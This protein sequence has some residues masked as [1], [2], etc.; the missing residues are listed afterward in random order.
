MGRRH[1]SQGHLTLLP[2]KTHVVC[3]VARVEYQ[4]AGPV[5]LF[6]FKTAIPSLGLP[7]SQAV[8]SGCCL[9]VDA[10]GDGAA[11][12]ELPDLRQGVHALEPRPLRDLM[13]IAFQCSMMNPCPSPR[14]AFEAAPIST[15]AK[16]KPRREDG[17]VD[18]ETGQNLCRATL[19]PVVVG[20]FGNRQ[21]LHF[22]PPTV[23]VPHVP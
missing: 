20:T 7:A 2:G 1:F 12:R 23:A 3:T 17:A 13:S 19:M 16:K 6:V 21:A 14:Y 5:Q 15:G 4:P 18:V 10:C 8:T 22:V 9:P 11:R